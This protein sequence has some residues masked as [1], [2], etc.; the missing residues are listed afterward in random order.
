MNSDVTQAV[1]GD[2]IVA[3]NVMRAWTSDTTRGHSS[4]HIQKGEQALVIQAWEVGNQLRLRVLRA[5]RILVFS[6]PLHAFWQ[7]WEVA[8][9]APR[10]PT[11]GC[12]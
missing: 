10:F 8:R 2:L 6:C 5:S 11:S 1:P 7:N 9:T 12:P 4:I 3:L